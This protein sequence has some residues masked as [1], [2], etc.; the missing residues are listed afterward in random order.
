[1]GKWR[2]GKEENKAKPGGKRKRGCLSWWRIIESSMRRKWCFFPRDS[3]RGF[4][5]AMEAFWLGVVS[6]TR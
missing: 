4:V 5:G 2:Q 1:M 3:M 6:R